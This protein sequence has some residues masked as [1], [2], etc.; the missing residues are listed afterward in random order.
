MKV[1]NNENSGESV[2]MNKI[3]KNL[4][5]C[6]ILIAMAAGL[7]GCGGAAQDKTSTPGAAPAKKVV[8]YTNAD[9]EA[10]DAMEKSLKEAGYEGK[11]V[12][13]TLG[14]SELG[15]K[16][17]AEGD[18]IEANLVTM[19]S[20]FLDSAQNKYKMFADLTFET[21]ALNTYPSYYAPI[22]ANTGAIFVN[23]EGA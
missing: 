2:K 21:K 12:L 18:K 10:A 16:L 14:T 13:Q 22:L 9:K 20:Y 5:L 3:A 11:Y 15:G 17:M 23:T 6:L 4:L 1:E 7:S 8:I 19:S